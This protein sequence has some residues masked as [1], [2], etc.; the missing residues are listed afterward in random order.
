[1][2]SHFVGFNE[3]YEIPDIPKSVR[4]ARG[5]SGRHSERLV[6]TDKIIEHEIERQG[7]KMVVDFL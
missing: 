5:H 7:V 6:R 1:M 2:L 3:L 4:H